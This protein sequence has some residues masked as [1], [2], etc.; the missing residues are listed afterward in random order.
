MIVGC[1]RLKIFIHGHNGRI[2]NGNNIRG[3]I[4][5]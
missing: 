4:N 2:L 5:R 1:Y 3:P